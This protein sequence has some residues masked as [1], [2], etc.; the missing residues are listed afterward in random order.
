M[1]QVYDIKEELSLSDSCLC[2]LTPNST[3]LEFGSATGYATRYMT[4]K[5]N[6]K[7]TC[8]EINPQMAAI[9]KQYAQKMIIADIESDEWEKEVVGYFDYIVFADVLEH[10]RNPAEIISRATPFLSENGVILTSIP[11]I[12]HNAI[13]MNLRNG[14]FNYTEIGLL[15]NTH[16]HFLTRESITKIFQTNNLYCL[17]EESKVIRPCDTELETYYIQNPLLALSL[18]SK[19]DGHIYRYVQKW[20]KIKPEISKTKIVGERLSLGQKIVELTYDLACYIKRKLK[21]ET[22]RIIASVMQKPIIEKDK[23]R[24][25]KYNS[26][27]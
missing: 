17:A 20:G 27:S 18:I 5:F 15:D 10:L 2:F 26:K 21:I 16:I 7:V 19:K 23:K 9:G 1:A 25:D 6:C 11:N 14:K 8:I 13:I 22:P 3:V 24:Y 12:G 4:E